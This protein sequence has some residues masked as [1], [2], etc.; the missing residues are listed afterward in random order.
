MKCKHVSVMTAA[1]ALTLA[2]SS[3]AQIV[4]GDFEDGTTQ[5][6]YQNG[7]R[8][9]SVVADP[10]GNSSYVLAVDWGGAGGFDWSI[11]LSDAANPDLFLLANGGG[12]QKVEFDIIWDADN[13]W[14]GDGWIQWTQIAYNYDGGWTQVGTPTAG[15]RDWGTLSGYGEQHPEWD[16]I[17]NGTPLASGTSF[18]QLFLSTNT[19]DN[20]ALNPIT[21]G[22]FY[23][24]NIV[25]T[26]PEPA[27]FALFGLGGLLLFAR[28]CFSR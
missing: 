20:D 16:F 2:G 28:R 9:I 22:K 1:V 27:A 15:S 4:I 11:G 6:W 14:S 12:P 23:I 18:A 8:P 26:V 24:D 25:I 7:S 5:G 17:A 13:D 21:R 10:S 19:G 3:Q